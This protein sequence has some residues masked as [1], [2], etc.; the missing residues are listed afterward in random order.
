VLRCRNEYERCAQFAD[1]KYP[2]VMDKTIHRTDYFNVLSTCFKSYFRSPLLGRMHVNKGVYVDQL[3][4]WFTNFSPSQ[5]LIVSL[6]QFEQY[7]AEIFQCILQFT[8]AE[9]LSSAVNNILAKCPMG[10]SNNADM[11]WNCC[12][13]HPDLQRM[14]G[15]SDNNTVFQPDVL[16]SNSNSRRRSVNSSQ[17]EELPA[18]LHKSLMNFYRRYEA[19]LQQLLGRKLY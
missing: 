10:S 9:S 4:R 13:I 8:G 18:H 12:I 2:N 7:P 17:A 11:Y 3:H 16:L 14:R 19:A 6:E 1:F 5:F 15:E